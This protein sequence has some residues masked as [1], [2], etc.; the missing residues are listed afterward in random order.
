MRRSVE[1]NDFT[2]ATIFV[3]PLQ[4]APGEDL[5]N[6]PRDIE[7]DTEQA[8]E[9]GVDLLFVPPDEAMYPEPI[10]TTV[11][12]DVGVGFMESASRP[13]HFD[14]VSTVVAK[15]FALVGPCRAYFG[16][17]DFQQLAVVRR[18]ARDLSF[19][20]DVIGCPTVR[21][22]DGLA[23]SSRNAY[24]TP[25]ERRSAV[26]LHRAL[27]AGAD[28]VAAGAADPDAV[29]RLMARI[30][31]DEPLARLDYAEVV[32]ADTLEPAEEL[33]GSLRLLV[34]AV[35]GRARLLDNLGVSA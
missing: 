17:K 27:T 6:Y 12:V 3:N 30:I 1:Q 23:M 4:F 15:L 10:R 35:L 11:S 19:P 5:D 7:G 21:E 31:D 18:M 28:L 22:A 29:R 34:S 14:G 26:V 20:V 16:E 8:V 13:T 9:A 24:L 32:V 25:D 2:V 33:R